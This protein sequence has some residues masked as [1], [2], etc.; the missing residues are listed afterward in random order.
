L[1]EFTSERNTLAALL[2]KEGRANDA[3]RV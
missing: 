2:K 3:D 1:A